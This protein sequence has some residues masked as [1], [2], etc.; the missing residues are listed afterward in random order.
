MALAALS[1]VAVLDVG[2]ATAEAAPSASEFAGTYVG[3]DARGWVSQWTVTISDGGRITGLRSGFSRDK[4]S[5]QV[6]A[7]GGYSLSVTATIWVFAH[8]HGHSVGD[9][10]LEI[11]TV[12][13]KSSGNIALDGYGNVVGTDDTGGSF[14]WVRQ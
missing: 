2:S 12:N 11:R 1:A 6:S 14:I 8:P 9:P 3:G 7:D 4:I 13:Y 10:D 5:G